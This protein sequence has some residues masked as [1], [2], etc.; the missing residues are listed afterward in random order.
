MKR[1]TDGTEVP[2]L[3]PPPGAGLGG[4]PQSLP[5][6][7]KGTRALKRI[8]AH[9][10]VSIKSFKWQLA[11]RLVPD[12]SQVGRHV[13][14]M[15][16]LCAVAPWAL[17]FYGEGGWGGVEVEKGELQMSEVLDPCY[18]LLIFRFYLRLLFLPCLI[19]CFK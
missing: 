2:D 6:S 16:Q 18:V 8:R 14:L 1:G 12:W 3:C 7:G 13:E 17:F 15:M 11:L 10:S 5:K 4:H 19:Y 9:C